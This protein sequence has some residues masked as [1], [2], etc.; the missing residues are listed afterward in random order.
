MA[1]SAGLAA[2]GIAPHSYALAVAAID[3]L[4]VLLFTAVSSLIF[5]RKPGDRLAILGGFTLLLFGFG[6]TTPIAMVATF[7]G[8][9][10]VSNL[11]F[12]LS[13]GLLV[14]FIFVFPDG[15]FVPR[16]TRMFSVFWMAWVLSWPF[17]GI[18]SP[19]SLPYLTRDLVLVLFNV[20]GA[21]FQIYR[22]RSLSSPA[23]K[24]QT[25]WV[26]FGGVAAIVLY[27]FSIIPLGIKPL[28]P[29]SKVLIDYAI[30]VI[31]YGSV[32][33]LPIVIAISILRFRLWDIDLV[34]NRALV[35][36]ILTAILALVFVGGVLI[37]QQVATAFTG[38]QLSSLALALSAVG[39]ALLFQPV[40]LRLQT[41]IDQR[42]YPK[43][44]EKAV[45]Q[46]AV[47]AQPPI[48]GGLLTG[49]HLGAYEVL[50]PIGRGGMAEIYK[51]RHTTLDRM[52][53]IK[54]LTASHAG[55]E[56]FRKRFE[57]EARTVALLR[58]PNIVQVFDFGETD[59]T[60]Y[61]AMEY[62][63]GQDLG[64][65]LRINGAL[66]PSQARP[67]LRGIIE[68]LD[69]AHQQNVVHR[70]VKP[71][72]VML[73]PVT[74]VTPDSGPYHPILM[75]F[76]IAKLLDS[77]SGLTHTGT[78]GTLDYIAPEQI[79]ASSSVD[80]RADIYALGIMTYQ[81][82]TGQLPFSGDNP[83]ALVL[84][85]LQRPVPDP[86]KIAPGLS[87]ATSAAILRAL[88]K[89]PADRFGTASAFG[90]ALAL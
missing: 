86:R 71:A 37:M 55:D 8:W 89:E 65:Y 14:V 2:S 10:Q 33:I 87:A 40:R 59:G 26:A 88:A 49:Q 28:S 82:L 48:Q 56:I 58:H 4:F 83:G 18:I 66:I 80:N 12:S 60:Y 45:Q 30:T 21:L 20:P 81:M 42:F 78:M 41:Q 32:M 53:A 22:Y 16:W 11:I 90:T 72:N 50:E 57:R 70:D 63:P 24:Q 29:V 54:T 64:H 23:Q 74:N 13:I 27:I 17:V 38:G 31:H 7:S 35:F 84:A 39:I 6:T 34:I 79:I 52:V 43:Y 5:W 25:K 51:G 1:S 73:Q 69:Y 67:L 44:L 85:H 47:L 36:G 76:G 75:D 9:A 68:A 62:I 19:L 15:Q 77:G 61:M 46:A 3:V